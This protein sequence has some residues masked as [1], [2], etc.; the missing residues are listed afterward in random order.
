MTSHFTS[1]QLLDLGEVPFERTLNIQKQIHSL[2]ARDLIPDTYILVEHVPGVYTI[3]R[4][5]KRENFPGIEPIEIERGGDVTYHGPGQLVMYPIVRVF[6]SYNSMDI[7]L[8]VKRMENIVVRA[9]ENMKFNA[10]FGEEPGIWVYNSPDGDRKVCSVGMKIRDGV[11]FHGIS[12][13]YSS[14]CLDGFRKIHPCG[15]DPKIM[16]YLGKSRK[17]LRE[18]LIKSI[19]EEDPHLSE[20]SLDKILGKLN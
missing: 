18:N 9:L 10:H 8:F 13:N 19:E 2:R 1:S 12:I 16:G 11:S 7:P 4:N 14:E 15:L 5:S 17:E 3:G 6:Y 20:I